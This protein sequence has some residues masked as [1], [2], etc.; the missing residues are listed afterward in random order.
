MNNERKIFI[1]SRNSN[2]AKKQSMLVKR[3]FLNIG[4]NNIYEK[5]IVSSGDILNFKK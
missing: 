5:Y 3:S 2:L 4:I 1:G